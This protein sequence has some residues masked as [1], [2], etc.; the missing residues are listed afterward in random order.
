MRFGDNEVERT[1]LVE[2]SGEVRRTT[3]KGMLFF[4]GGKEAWLPRQFV[5]DNRDGTFTMPLW[6]A[7][8][9]GFV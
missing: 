6:L 2:V 7:K 3:E 5:E 1:Q 4:D 9:K 8:D